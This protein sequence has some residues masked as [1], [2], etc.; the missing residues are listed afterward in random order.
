M[1]EDI[2]IPKENKHSKKKKL[3]K[4][5]IRLNNVIDLIKIPINQL[6]SIDINSLSGNLYKK[7]YEEA[8]IEEEKKIHKNQ[9]NLKD[10]NKNPKKKANKV[11]TENNYPFTSTSEENLNKKR[12]NNSV[13][14]RKKKYEKKMEMSSSSSTSSDGADKEEN[15]EV[16]G[17]K[18]TK[19]NI[20]SQRN[21]KVNIFNLSNSY[22]NLN[23]Y[24][25]PDIITSDFDR[26]HIR[27]VNKNYNYY[28]STHN[29]NDKSK[30]SYKGKN[31]YKSSYLKNIEEVQIDNSEQSYK[32][33]NSN[34]IYKK[35]NN[36]L[37]YNN[38]DLESSDNTLLNKHFYYSNANLRNNLT[39][40]YP[41][42]KIIF[43]INYALNFGEEM[44][45]LGSLNMLGNWEERRVLK[46]KWNNG[47]I[48]KG[49]IYVNSDIVKDFEF[50][51]VI[52][53]ENKIKIWENGPNNKFN[54][55]AMFNQI[56]V[57]KKG[58]Y[59][60]YEYEY[61]INTGELILFCNWSC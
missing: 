60:K 14:S 18:R 47:N 21:K 20:F 34:N 1:E 46:L 31:N 41:L 26:N 49:E 36:N 43:V 9:N 35:G 8:L 39:L 40:A 55:E 44:G 11:T 5:K 59:S 53:Q 52:L 12:N 3:S 42:K 7:I 45:I 16:F 10:K 33:S 32:N 2:Y 17:I 15:N 28:S 29:N 56:R 61:N 23:F 25:E 51:L 30:S 58:S 57:R 48:W 19:T 4:G 6:H 13:E 50:K 54:Y 24:K 38:F 22:N 37:Y 27:P